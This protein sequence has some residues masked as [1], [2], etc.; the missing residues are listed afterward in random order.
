MTDMSRISSKE[1]LKNPSVG[2]PYHIKMPPMSGYKKTH[3]QYPKITG[4][5]NQRNISYQKNT[6]KSLVNILYYIIFLT[7]YFII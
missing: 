5:K 3:K 6:D 2:K 4:Y 1:S 7:I